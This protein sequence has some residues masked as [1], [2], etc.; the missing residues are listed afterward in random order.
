MTLILLNPFQKTKQD[1]TLANTMYETSFTLVK[2]KKVFSKK[3]IN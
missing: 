3:G 1:R 2:G